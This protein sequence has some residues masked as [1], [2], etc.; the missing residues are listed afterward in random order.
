MKT[1]TG[2]C[3]CKNITYSVDMDTEIV[4]ATECNCSICEP[5]GSL[6]V[7]V[8][9]ENFTLQNPNDALTEYQFNKKAIRHYFCKTCGVA[10]HGEGVEHPSVALNVRTVDGVE[11]QGIK[12]NHYNGKD[13]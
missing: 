11:L 6:L 1:Y 10:T 8:P 2:G 9:K 5:K 3:H 4:E 12:R 13:V 7:F